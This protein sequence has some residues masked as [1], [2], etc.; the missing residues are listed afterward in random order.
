MKQL[1]LL[2]EKKDFGGEVP[3]GG[4]T[5]T[6]IEHTIDLLAFIRHIKVA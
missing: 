2:D 6:S 5:G 3:R 4:R 1:L